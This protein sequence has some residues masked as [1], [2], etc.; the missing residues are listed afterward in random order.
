MLKFH[1]K[2]TLVAA[3]A[4]V[5][6]QS[7]APAIDAGRDAP[8][9]APAESCVQPED[10]GNEL[11]VGRFCSPRRGQCAV[12]P[13]ARVCVPDLAPEVTDW[14]C[15]R[16]CDDDS[17]CGTGALCL[18]DSRGMG[19][20]PVVCLPPM[21]D[22]G[23]A[24]AGTGS[25]APTSPADAPGPTADAPPAGVTFCSASGDCSTG[26]E[27]ALSLCTGSGPDA[28]FCVDTGRPT[29][30]GFGGLSCPPGVYSVCLGQGSCIA[31]AP[32]ICV[33]PE[34]Q[35]AICAMQPTLWSCP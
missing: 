29:C 17:D 27:C 26:Q 15:T 13:F 3:V 32:G 10:E 1:A 12:T 16:F 35:T 25:D 19:C 5:A 6:C 8:I 31:D 23:P 18:G 24:D 20:V 4:L 21:A 11:G 9:V 22:G 34:E 28:G 7:A 33:T 2:L 14:Y 30:G